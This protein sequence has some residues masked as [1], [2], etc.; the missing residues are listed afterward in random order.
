MRK[1]LLYAAG[2]E[3]TRTRQRRIPVQGT[4]RMRP[5]GRG[6]AL[7]RLVRAASPTVRAYVV[8][9]V[10]SAAE[11]QTTPRPLLERVRDV[12][13]SAGGRC[14]EREARALGG[15]A[16]RDGA[17]NPL[18]GAGPIASLPRMPGSMP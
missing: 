13:V 17:P 8:G 6:R 2:P 18:A 12:S 7:H 14:T 5:P 9:R 16:F 3:P 1:A 4:R 10:R 11:M 15:E